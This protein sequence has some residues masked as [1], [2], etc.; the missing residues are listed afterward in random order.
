M[1][2]VL[3][4]Y[5]KKI[6]AATFMFSA[7]IIV[8]FLIQR[9]NWTYLQPSGASLCI[10]M[11]SGAIINST[12][13]DKVDRLFMFSPNAFFYGFLPIIIYSAG[14]NLQ[15]KNF[16]QDFWTISLFA[17]VGTVISAFVFGL[18]T[19]FL[20]LIGIISKKHLGSNRFLECLMYGTLISATDP[21]ATLSVFADVKAPPLLY[22]LV[23]GESVLNDAVAVVLFRTLEKFYSVDF[24]IKTFFT[25]I[26]Q[27]IGV[28]IG[29][30]TIG[31]LCALVC[32]FTTKRLGLN[33][34]G[35]HVAASYNGTA[36]TFALLL[37][38]GY[39]SYVIAEN[40]GCSGI[41]SIFFTGIG[42]AHYSYHN[43]GA[44][45]KVA[46]FKSFEAIAFLSETFVFAYL[47]LQVATAPHVFDVG[48]IL[49]GFP[50]A[51]ASRFANI[52]PL[53]KVA[54]EV[55]T[56]KIPENIQKMHAACGLRGAV[57]YALALAMPSTNPSANVRGSPAIETAT[58]VICVISTL[59]LGGACLP[60]MQKWKLHD[61]DDVSHSNAFDRGDYDDD[62]DGEIANDPV[63]RAEMRAIQDAERAAMGGG[64]NHWSRNFTKVKYFFFDTWDKVEYGFMRPTFGGR[65]IGGS[66]GAGGGVG[67]GGGGVGVGRAAFSRLQNEDE[68]EDANATNNN[69]SDNVELGNPVTFAANAAA[70]K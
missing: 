15:R 55:R 66:S 51:L 48:M 64:F 1:C 14:L 5:V 59:G 58:L 32:A 68:D 44:E 28:S 41:M 12:M 53:S 2:S 13:H 33:D 31:I 17:F 24:T 56:E 46:V 60:L 38:D 16:F 18:G 7:C 45:A 22:N 10:G 70:N 49:F 67:S 52:F 54:N 25:V 69:G 39:F 30:M 65:P 27:F 6:Q 19:W 57:A 23:F 63:M 43:V 9:F 3:Y 34:P 11:I 26:F 21:V 4:I 50:L 62:N 29:S 37:L 20:T 40:V 8:S 47:G 42:N 61:P 36:Y 35:V